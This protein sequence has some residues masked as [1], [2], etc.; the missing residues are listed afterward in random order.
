MPA[1]PLVIVPVRSVWFW[2]LAQEPLLML[3]TS[4]PGNAVW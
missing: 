2:T 3:L 4:G 1:I